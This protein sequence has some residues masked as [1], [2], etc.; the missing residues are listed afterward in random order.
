MLSKKLMYGRRFMRSENAYIA[1]VKD[2]ETEPTM[3]F[4]GGE[5]RDDS[6]MSY[7][8]VE[9]L[10]CDLDLVDDMFSEEINDYFDTANSKER[11][12]PDNVNVTLEVRPGTPGW[13]K[14]VMMNH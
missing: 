14:F 8:D 12:S 6:D 10:R 4:K 11:S 2:F 7:S 5:E 3:T 9:S 13:G 1:A